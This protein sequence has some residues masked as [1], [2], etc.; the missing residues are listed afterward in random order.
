MAPRKVN[1]WYG[2]SQVDFASRGS[3]WHTPSEC[4]QTI[5]SDS[6]CLQESPINPLA[7]N[8]QFMLP[9]IADR[10]VDWLRAH[11]DVAVKFSHQSASLFLLPVRARCSSGDLAR[12]ES[13]LCPTHRTAGGRDFSRERTEI[14][15]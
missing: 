7:R 1:R 9:L 13:L 11:P 2:F 4:T 3:G 12:P 8:S 10:N 5:V 6:V 15:L 14:L